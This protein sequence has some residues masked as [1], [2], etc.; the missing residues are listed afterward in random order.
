MLALHLACSLAF[1]YIFFSLVEYTTHRWLMHRMRTAR[2]LGLKFL[3][4]LCFNHM[5][6]HHKRGYDHEDH[7]EDDHLS[8]ILI[9]AA[10]VGMPMVPIVWL[11][12]PFTVGVGVVFSVVYSVGWWLVHLEMHRKEGRFFARNAIFRFLER[13]HQLHHHYPNTNY[14]V[15]LP[16]W[17]WLLGTYHVTEDQ[18]RKVSRSIAN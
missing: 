18:R 5:A 3:A 7:E 13:R 15:V 16:L 9:A 1:V 12:D 2:A 11:I 8:H 17:D 10:C 4:T 6:L 14:N